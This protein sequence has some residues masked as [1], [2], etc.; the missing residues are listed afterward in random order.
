MYCSSVKIGR[1]HGSRRRFC[2]SMSRRWCGRRI[3][4]SGRRPNGEGTI[5]QRRDGRWEGAAYVLLPSGGRARKRVYGKTRSEVFAKLAEL[6]QKTR[7]GLPAISGQMTIATYLNEWLETVAKPSVRPS[8]F[9][10]YR[11]YVQD[12]LI[13]ALGNKRL[14]R[15]TPTDYGPSSKPKPMPAWRPPPSNRC[16]RSCEPHCSMPCVRI[17]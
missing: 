7:S 15:L 12:H 9:Y 1:S 5:Y 13:P 11:L 14:T 2:M 17:W 16:T 10:S 8:M 4:V 3:R 6:Q